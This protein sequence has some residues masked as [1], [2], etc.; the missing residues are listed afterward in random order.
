VT[1]AVTRYHD[2]SYGHN[3]RV[4]FRVEPVKGLDAVGRVMDFSA[5]KAKLCNWLEDNWDHKFLAWSEDAVMSGMASTLGDAF[6]NI[7]GKSIVFVPFNPTAENMAR[8]LVEVVAPRE[9][10]GTGC[11]LTACE[12]QETRKCSAAFYKER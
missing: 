12:V 11:V 8:Y 1:F 10:V 6:A 7:I 3:G 9:L 5:I 4:Y 2:F